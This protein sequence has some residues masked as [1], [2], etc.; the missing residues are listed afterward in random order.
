MPSFFTRHE[1]MKLPIAPE[2]MKAFSLD[3][4]GVSDWVGSSCM[5]TDSRKGFVGSE[6]VRVETITMHSEMS[7]ST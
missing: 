4:K 2:S 3:E 6:A 7:L 5:R 1:C